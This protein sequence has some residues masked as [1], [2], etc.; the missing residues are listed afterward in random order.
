MHFHPAADLLP[1]LAAAIAPPLRRRVSDSAARVVKVKSPS[2]A[3]MPW[4][5]DITPYMV[6]PMDMLESRHHQALIFIASAQSGKTQALIDAWIAHTITC[7]PS[8]MMVIQA[9]QGVARDYERDRW[10]PLVKLSPD[11]AARVS[12]RGHD[13]NTY[14]KTLLSGDTIY[15]KWPSQN[16]L[17]GKAIR[18]MALTDYD[19]MPQSIGNQGSPFDLARERTTTYRSLGMTLV[20]SSPGHEQTDPNWRP[21]T[22]HQA[23][24]SQGIFSLYN[25]GDRRRLYWPCPHCHDYFLSPPG[26]DSFVYDVQTDLLDC[27][28]PDTLGPVHIAC[29]ACGQLISEAHRPAMLAAARWVPDHCTIAPDGQLHGT[30]STTDIASYWLHGCHAAFVS[31]RALILRYLQA[32]AIYQGTGDEESLRTVTLQ[33]LAAPYISPTRQGARNAHALSARQEDYPRATVPEGARFLLAAIDIQGGARR[34]FVV[35]VIAYGPHLESWLIDRYSLRHLDDV[36]HTPLDMSGNI[37]HWDILIP[38]VLERSY[39]LADGSGRHLPIHLTLCDSGGEEGVTDRAYS[40]YRSLRP[41]GLAR[42]FLLVKGSSSRTAPRTEIRHPDTR[43][44]KDRKADSRG[45]VPVLFLNTNQLKDTVANN[46]NRQT[47]GPG[48]MHFP[49]WVGD[50]F[51]DELNGE[52]RTPDGAWEKVS[53]NEAL[54]LYAYAQA[55]CHHLKADVMNWAAPRHWAADWSVNPDIHRLDHP[56]A[57][58]R[59]PAPIAPAR[60][61]RFR[62]RT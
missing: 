7:S 3:V 4:S 21:Q 29:T 22:P 38:H 20:E 57:P 24:P 23:P 14:D 15:L 51:F 25:L 33:K 17:Q 18:R 40:F 41:R 45:D 59:N 31:W 37:E 46:L 35:Q 36:N 54:D 8:K 55:G 60:P 5:R 19:R 9:T 28:I 56:S 50:W 12:P 47:P 27:V 58:D 32:L 6:E 49:T 53:A 43:A 42:R 26:P 16:E 52:T 10:R 30:P 62:Q 13:D 2:G 11:I 48:Y 44:R 1:D 34:R 39:P 61:V